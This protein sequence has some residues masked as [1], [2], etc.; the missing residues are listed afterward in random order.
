MNQHRKKQIR[1]KTY[2]ESDMRIRHKL[3]FVTPKDPWGD[4]QHY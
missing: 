1:D 2:D 3:S 4:K